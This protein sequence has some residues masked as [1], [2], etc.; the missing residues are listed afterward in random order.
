MQFKLNCYPKLDECN[1]IA[2]AVCLTHRQVIV[3]FQ[4]RRSKFKRQML[5]LSKR[6]AGK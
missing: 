3:W 6:T 4:N 1:R 2:E 5:E